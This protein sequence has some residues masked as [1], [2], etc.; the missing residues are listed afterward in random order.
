MAKK[1][2]LLGMLALV[3][4]FGFAGCVVTPAMKESSIG[5]VPQIGVPVARN[6]EILGIIRC[7]SVVSG[8]TGEKITYDALL[9]ES[10]KLG[11]N[12][13]V[14]IMIDVQ[15][16]G[17]LFSG[18]KDTWY[19]SALAVKYSNLTLEAN[20]GSAST[21]TSTLNTAPGA[22]EEK[23]KGLLGLGFLGL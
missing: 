10:E 22:G 8:G 7:E 14:N 23:K 13:I 5:L 9:R 1:G 3:L 2:F 16:G 18:P 6:V 11:G 20:A 12:G 21:A 19:A 4:A 17:S 15:H